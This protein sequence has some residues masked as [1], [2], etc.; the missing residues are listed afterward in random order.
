ML[1][2]HVARIVG[3]TEQET[4]VLLAELEDAGVFSRTKDG[5]I[6]S[7]R[8]VRDDRQLQDD[9][10]NGRRGGNPRLKGGVN[11][12]VNPPVNPEANPPLKARSQKSEVRSQNQEEE[13]EPRCG[14]AAPPAEL[15]QWAAEQAKRPDWLPT[16]KPWITAS[17]WLKL[18][19]A[20]KASGTVTLDDYAAIVR[21]ARDSRH[22]LSNPAAFIVARL[23][24]LT[25]GTQ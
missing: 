7:R 9:V 1:S 3:T 18:G 6:Y 11:P 17:V 14:P 21:E 24:A 22:T 2:C 5:T 10:K 12:P 13:E 4:E 20:V 23:K 16:G 19:Q 25:K 15:R 8:M